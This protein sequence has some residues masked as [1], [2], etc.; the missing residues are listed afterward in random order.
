LCSVSRAQFS[1][2]QYTDA[3]IGY[4]TG[5]DT[6]YQYYDEVKNTSAENAML[7]RFYPFSTTS[8]KH[9]Y[10]QIH[11]FTSPQPLPQIDFIRW[12]SWA[13]DSNFFNAHRMDFSINADTGGVFFYLNKSYVDSTTAFLIIPGSG[14]NQGSS[15]AMYYPS[16]YHNSVCAAASKCRNYGDVYT[17]VRPNEDFAAI[18]TG[19]SAS[20]R[21]K[22]NYTALNSKTNLLNQNWAT[23]CYIQINA[24]TK[25]LKSKYKKVVVLGLSSGSWGAFFTSLQSEPDAAQIASGYSIM[26]NDLTYSYGPDQLHF[27]GLFSSHPI[28]SIRAILKNQ[29]TQYLFSYG[30]GDGVTN[31]ATENQ[32]HLTQNFFNTPDTLHNLGFFYNFTTHRF[33]CEVLDSFFIRIKKMPKAS[34]NFANECRSDSAVLKIQFIGTPPY[35]FDLYRDNITITSYTSVADSMFLTLLTEGE[36]EIRNLMDAQNVPGF[37][38]T[39]I[40]YEKHPALQWTPVSS[41]Y[42]CSEDSSNIMLHVSGTAPWNIQYTKNGWPSQ[43]T[44]FQNDTV[45]KS[46]NAQF[47]FQQ[48]EDAQHC[49]LILQDSV[50]LN[51]KPLDVQLLSS[52]YQCDSNK[53][54]VQIPVNGNKPVAVSYLNNGLP[55][56]WTTSEDTLE[57]W[58]GNGYYTVLQISDSTQCI[59]SA[60]YWLPI[61]YDS[62]QVNLGTPM[63]NCSSHTMALPFYV[64][65]NSPY[66]LQYEKDG[67]LMQ[68]LLAGSMV[69]PMDQAVYHFLSVT[70]QTGCSHEID[71]W[72][73]AHSDTLDWD[74]VSPVYDCDNY[75][76][77]LE[78]HFQGNPPFQLHYFGNGIPDSVLTSFSTYSLELSNGTYWIQ[79]VSDSTGCSIPVAQGYTFQ[80]QP[81]SVNLVQQ[82][83]NC[84]SQRYEMLWQFTG[85]PPYFLHY[86]NGSNWFTDTIST[87]PYVQVIPNGNWMISWAEDATHCSDS[88]NIPVS[89]NF[90]S[91]SVVLTGQHY[92]CTNHQLKVDIACTGTAPWQI[93]CLQN[94]PVM[95][96]FTVNSVNPNFSIWLPQG[97]FTILQMTDGNNCLIP[98]NQVVVNNFEALTVWSSTPVYDCDSLKAKLEWAFTGNAPWILHYKEYNLIQDYYDTVWTP[99]LIKYLN[100]GDYSFEVVNDAVCTFPLSDTLHAHYVPLQSTLLSSHVNCDSDRYEVKLYTSGGVKPYTLSYWQ[101]GNPELLNFYQDTLTLPTPN[102]SYYF[103]QVQDSLQC[104]I[105]L[106]STLQFQYQAPVWNAPVSEYNCSKDSSAFSFNVQP[107]SLWL[108]YKKD[109]GGPDSIFLHSTMPY[110]VGNGQY[111]WLYLRDSFN[112]ID[113]VLQESVVNEEPIRLDSLALTQECLQREYIYRMTLTGK[114][115]WVLDYTTDNTSRQLVVTGSPVQWKST[116]GII[117]WE[118]LSDANGCVLALN[119]W[120]TLVPF[121]AADPELSIS[122]HHL[123]TPSP[124]SAYL[125]YKN[126]LLM[127][128]IHGHSRLSEGDGEYQVIVKDKAGCYYPSNKVMDQ[129]PEDVNLFPNPVQQSA[130]LVLNQD[131]GDYWDYVVMDMRGQVVEKGTEYKTY[132][133]FNW[134]QLATGKYWIYI[135]TQPDANRFVLPFIKN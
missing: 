24:L 77:R 55:G 71:Q 4:Y 47:V 87:N 81:F 109:A 92:D 61:H 113:S 89:I 107:M 95:N 98:F 32:N 13:S 97:T 15:V 122:F 74:V 19:I 44:L 115:P 116:T 96:Q 70:D 123:N 41:Q 3:I 22:L 2:S 67:V 106:D 73:D 125:W 103:A 69:W 78:F 48:I 133:Y 7:Q 18:W 104:N 134:K 6:M 58:L 50:A 130:T 16:N 11:C 21:R 128:S 68:D 132:H 56:V 124:G 25:Y 102:G 36:Y 59:Q 49:Q 105:A 80:Y 54:Q 60:Y 23:N 91:P 118:K 30:S 112:C 114:S 83:Y 63:Y 84:D 62:L 12:I 52:V 94:A 39:P 9:S 27:D 90:Q 85:N 126:G 88:V 121:L 14:T 65:G 108:Y 40:I 119:R 129:Y 46:S 66:L 33:P 57:L 120:D 1:T 82:G 29:R 17:F 135:T 131:V 100:N 110:W 117:H 8:F 72:I 101:N 34:L 43:W 51:F 79:Q 75:T 93:T 99:S 127:D 5:V 111:Q 28:D 45:I 26:F 10:E 64:S 31:M 35:Q 38:V 53:T 86:Q 76:T 20:Q 42:I 37:K